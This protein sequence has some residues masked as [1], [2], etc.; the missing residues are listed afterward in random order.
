MMEVKPSLKIHGGW[1][2]NSS[3]CRAKHDTDSKITAPEEYNTE[4]LDEMYWYTLG[5][6]V[7][8]GNT[9]LGLGWWFWLDTEEE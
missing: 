3:R 9:E 6:K 7:R 1:V 5:L 2:V 8:R 4:D